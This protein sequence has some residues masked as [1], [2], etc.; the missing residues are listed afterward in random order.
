MQC[1]DDEIEKLIRAGVIDIDTGLSYA[2]NAGNMRL[3]L[4][5][6]LEQDSSVPS[7]AKEVAETKKAEDAAVAT[8]PE[9][10]FEVHK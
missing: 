3:Q 1:F 8:D 7:V 4:A 9:L 2:T 5:D 10:E 6:L